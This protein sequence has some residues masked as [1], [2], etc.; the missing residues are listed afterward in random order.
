MSERTVRHRT[1]P[2]ND[3]ARKGHKRRPEADTA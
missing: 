2:N 3:P 1:A